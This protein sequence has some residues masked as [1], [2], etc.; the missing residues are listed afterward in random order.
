MKIYKYSS[1]VLITVFAVTVLLDSVTLHNQGTLKL[2]GLKAYSDAAGTIEIFE[3]DWGLIDEGEFINFSFFAKTGTVPITLIM[4]VDAYV[5]V[6]A[7]WYLLLTWD[8]V[9][10]TIIP[11]ITII[12][13]TLT[14]T[15][16]EEVWDYINVI[17]S[18]PSF[19]FDIYITATETV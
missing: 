5:P 18:Q 9:P 7:E 12:P 2:V 15:V 10:G 6:E 4:Y 14:L 8:Y 1:I 3:V 17:F 16:T 19:T 11:P 13:L